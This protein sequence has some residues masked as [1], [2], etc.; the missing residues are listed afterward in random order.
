MII[1]FTALDRKIERERGK[2]TSRPTD[3]ETGDRETAEKNR[4]RYKGRDKET[5]TNI[6]SE[7]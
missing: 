5:E 2:E 6:E 3:R 1:N 7:T 4:D